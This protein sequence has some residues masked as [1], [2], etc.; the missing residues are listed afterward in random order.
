M[1]LRAWWSA[2]DS[3]YK[4]AFIGAFAA[5]FVAVIAAITAKWLQD[6]KIK[7]EER[8]AAE[9]RRREDQRALP[10]LEVVSQATS[11]DRI[12]RIVL[13]NLSS[14]PVAITKVTFRPKGSPERVD[15]PE[16]F[17]G[18]ANDRIYVEFLYGNHK[19]AEPWIKSIDDH[20]AADAHVSLWIGIVSKVP[21]HDRYRY[22]G[23]LTIDYEGG[24]KLVL[25][26]VPVYIVPKMLKGS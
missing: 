18:E 11:A 23:T 5:I 9:N 13:H 8:Q 22:I 7:S 21:G 3:T 14:R 15:D 6:E 25:E 24:N 1:G 4:A 26:D 2:L 19:A 17:F 20:V 10:R 16:P 12:T